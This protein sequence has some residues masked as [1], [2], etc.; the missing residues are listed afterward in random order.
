MSPRLAIVRVSIKDKFRS[1]ERPPN[2]V[3]RGWLIGCG[4]V[5]DCGWL[6]NSEGCTRKI[7]KRSRSGVGELRWPLS[8]ML[9][10]KHAKR[11]G[12]KES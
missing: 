5:D 11:L 6:W 8:P 7:I 4:F 1:R 2:G 12:F 9:W 3:R 10:D